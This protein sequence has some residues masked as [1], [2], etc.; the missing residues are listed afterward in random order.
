MQ[1]NNIEISI[2]IVHYNVKKELF[3]CLYSIY[4]SEPRVSFEIIVVDNDEEKVIE[5]DLKNKFPKVVYVKNKN[6][7]WGGGVNKG[8]GYARGKYIYLLNPDTLFINNALDKIYEFGKDEPDI[9]I[10]SS[11]LFDTNKKVYPLQGTKL[12]NPV[13]AIFSLSFINKFFP[14]NPVARKFWMRGRDKKTVQQVESATLSA[15]LIR[16]DVLIKAGKFDENYFL[17]YEEYDLSKRL[18]KLEYK[19]FI[20]SE[21]KVVHIWEASAIKTGRTNEFIQESRKYYFKKHYGNLTASFVELILGLN[22]RNLFTYSAILGII[23]IGTFLR[24]DKLNLYAPFIGDQAWFYLSAR[25]VIISGQIP[26]LG[27]T[28]SHT[29]IHQG[30]LWTYMLV[31]VFTLFNFN[32]LSGVYLTAILGVISIIAAYKFGA[33]FISTKFGILFAFLF[34]LSPLVVYHSRFAYHTSPIPLFILIL[35]FAISKWIK[36]NVNYFPLVL[37]IMSILYNFELATVIFWVVIIFYLIYGAYKKKGYIKN[38]LSKQI[39]SFSILAL[40]IPMIPILIYDIQN[41]LPQTIVFAGWFFYKLLQVIG[42]VEKSMIDTSSFS[43]AFN[44]FF[45]KYQSL[46]F[47]IN[48]YVSYAVFFASVTFSFILLQRKG[49]VSPFGS[50]IFLTAVGLMAYFISGVSSEAYLVML[51]PGLLFMVTYL[52]YGIKSKYLI[53]SVSLVILVISVYYSVSSNYLTL[54]TVTLRDKIIA[55]YEV[56]TLVGDND[57]ILKY[58]GP[59]QQFESSVMPYEYLVWWVNQRYPYRS[60]YFSEILITEQENEIIVEKIN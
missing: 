57:Y 3:E 55:S 21:S 14:N 60:S 46:V 49:L 10:A 30:P 39:L 23:L 25:D 56:Y 6:T 43:S 50:V 35:F 12:L 27:I 34:A 19:N 53:A 38:I 36:G 42:F 8:L 24:F 13:S 32:P 40:L 44:F 7:G 59:G 22:K 31:P 20:V 28:S 1:K 11:L 33:T 18:K 47:P 5:T 41:G 54:N 26:L 4:K 9:G 58:R 15:A 29:W 45:V 37:F 17:Y 16:K 48:Q 51:F 52:I 2:I